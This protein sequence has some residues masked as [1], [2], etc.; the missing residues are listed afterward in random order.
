MLPQI[1]GVFGVVA[2]P[3]PSFSEKGNAWMRLR[4]VAKDRVRDSNGNWSDGDPLWMNAVIFGKQAEHLTDSVRKGD[5]IM[6]SGRLKP[7][8]WTDKEGVEHNDIQI[9]A[10]EVAV[11]MRW[12]PAKTPRFTEESG[13]GNV[14]AAQQSLGATQVEEAPF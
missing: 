8:V 11:S 12:N 2:D 7:N 10:D 14:A 3:E 13:Q 4:V 5:T 9:H 1:T 6:L